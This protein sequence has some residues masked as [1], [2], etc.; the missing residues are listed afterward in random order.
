MTNNTRDLVSQE[1]SERDR[2]RSKYSSVASHRLRSDRALQPSG[3]SACALFHRKRTR[4]K[5]R[6]NSLRGTLFTSEHCPG[7]H[8]SLVNYVR[9][10]II[11]GGQYSLRHRYLESPNINLVLKTPY[12]LVLIEASCPSCILEDTEW[13]VILFYEYVHVLGVVFYLQIQWNIPQ[14]ASKRFMA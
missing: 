4:G 14:S 1:F 2:A 10:E 8:Y 7:G 12:Q 11:H 6:H 13:R 9:V 3:F 5:G